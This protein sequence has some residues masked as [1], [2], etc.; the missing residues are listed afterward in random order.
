M[1]SLPS[2]TIDAFRKA[3]TEYANSLAQTPFPDLYGRSDGKRVGTAVEKT[4]T[5]FLAERFELEPGNAANG[6]DFPSLNLDLKVTSS[7]QPQS[8]S[9]YRESA[10][11]IYGLGYNLLVIVYDKRDEP[12]EQVAYLDIQH[13]IY[14]DKSRTGDYT[15]TKA[16]RDTIEAGHEAPGGTEALIED[17]DALLQDKG[18]PGDDVTRRAL[19][20]RLVAETPKQGYLTISNALQWRLQ[21]GRAI[22]VA[23][24]QTAGEEVTELRA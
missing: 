1:P 9:P 22:N 23:T 21:Y 10:Q 3:A 12:A 4:F 11:K 5:A 18:L 14:I 8:S 15:L 7:K 2:M 24:G 20:E 17:L 6:L 16:I 19:A 13:V